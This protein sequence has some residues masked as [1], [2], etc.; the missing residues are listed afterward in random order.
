MLVDV[1]YSVANSNFKVLIS[2]DAK[3][4]SNETKSMN[5]S[6][7]AKAP[8]GKGIK[9]SPNGVTVNASVIVAPDVFP[10]IN[11]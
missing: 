2:V 6:K 4:G 8:C 1:V 11:P 9:C 5:S 3:I 7:L 10:V